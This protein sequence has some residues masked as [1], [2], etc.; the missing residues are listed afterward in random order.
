MAFRNFD[1]KAHHQLHIRL[2]TKIYV[3]VFFCRVV[4]DSLEAKQKDREWL[5]HQTLGELDDTKLVDSLLG[6]KSVFKRRGEKDPLPGQQQKKPKLLRLLCDVSGSMY[7]FNIY[8]Q[9]LQRQ[10]GKVFF[11]DI[12]PFDLNV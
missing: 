11:N 12:L 1:E 4:I 2:L 3:F 7:R 9:R 10:L 8:D 6:E 5:K